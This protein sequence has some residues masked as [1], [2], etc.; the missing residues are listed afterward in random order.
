[1]LN[2]ASIINFLTKIMANIKKTI[3]SVRERKR[4]YN[5][6]DLV[7]IFDQNKKVRFNDY[8][9]KTTTVTQNKYVV[10]YTLIDCHDDYGQFIYFD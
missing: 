1:M 2:G 5:Q 9:Y 8:K 3:L 6:I 10:K 7:E 4:N